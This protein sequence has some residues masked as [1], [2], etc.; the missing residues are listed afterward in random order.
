MHLCGFLSLIMKQ[1]NRHRQNW[2]QIERPETN[3]KNKTVLVHMHVVIALTPDCSAVA[4]VHAGSFPEAFFP[5]QWLKETWKFSHTVGSRGKWKQ[6]QME[7]EA[8]GS[9]GNWKARQAGYICVRCFTH[10]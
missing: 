6:K 7:A 4:R 10:T 8:N 5:T 9:R 1:Q 3:S 2:I